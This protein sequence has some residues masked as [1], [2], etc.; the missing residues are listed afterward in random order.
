M[1]TVREFLADVAKRMDR[2]LIPG[3]HAAISIDAAAVRRWLRAAGQPFMDPDAAQPVTAR[4]L[5]QTAAWVVG[6]T[7]QRQTLFGGVAGAAGAASVPPEAIAATI[8]SLRL[9]QRLAVVYGFDPASDRGERAVWQ[10]VAAG[11]E[12][13]LPGDGPM[14]LRM[15]QVPTVLVRGAAARYP[16]GALAAAVLRQS[17]WT[18][19]K[20]LSRWFVLPGVSSAIAAA[21]AH[22]RVGQVGERMSSTL[23]RLADAPDVDSRRIV[24]A[25][26]VA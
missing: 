1:G 18:I 15:S 25:V 24:E 4:Q 22:Q 14:G 23:R 13:D 20:R 6:Q 16:N 2:S 7:R 9:A 12:L 26:E 5:E 3:V 8:S 21:G 19:G 17:A 11:F 10:A